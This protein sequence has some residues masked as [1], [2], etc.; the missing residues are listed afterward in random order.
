M[1]FNLPNKSVLFKP[2][3]WQ[4]NKGKKSKSHFVWETWKSYYRIKSFWKLC[5]LEI[6][7]QVHE[8]VDE[9]TE[10]LGNLWNEENK[11]SI[12]KVM[13]KNVVKQ[14]DHFLT[15]CRRKFLFLFR[16]CVGTVLFKRNM[17]IRIQWIKPA[18]KSRMPARHLWKRHSVAVHEGLW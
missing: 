4:F 15:T 18:P 17:N 5:L 2:A 7:E 6:I 1:W 16:V 14:F 13:Q 8:R 9:I 12:A 3:F 11:F 10:G